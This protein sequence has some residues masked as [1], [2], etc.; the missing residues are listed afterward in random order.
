MFPLGCLFC[1]W[2]D[3]RN[4]L[5]K[6]NHLWATHEGGDKGLDY[7]PCYTPSKL[8]ELLLI[9]ISWTSFRVGLTAVTVHLFLLPHLQC[10]FNDHLLASHFSELFTYATSF[11][12]SFLMQALFSSSINGWEILKHRGLCLTRT[13]LSVTILCCLPNPAQSKETS[14]H[15]F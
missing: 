12:F 13:G 7:E 8:Y 14:H 1:R 4:S 2:A 15:T 5:K 11:N 9:L 6:L 10:T 3:M